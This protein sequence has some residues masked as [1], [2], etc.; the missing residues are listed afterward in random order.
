M[1]SRES[2]ITLHV[3]LDANNNP[4]HLSWTATEGGMEPNR[5][6]KALMLHLWDV[7]E[8]N[9]MRIELWNQQFMVEEM[10]SFV[11]QALLSMADTLDRSTADHD[12]AADLRTFAQ[13]LAEKLEL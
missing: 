6:I 2:D 5:E 8:N 10:R 13:Q 7:K 3:K 12:A 9:S 4:I 11:F 1:E